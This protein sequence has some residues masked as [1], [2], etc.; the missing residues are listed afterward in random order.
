MRRTLLAFTLAGAIAVLS[1]GPAQALPSAACNHGTM[2]A[3]SRIPETTGSGTVTPGHEAVP[4]ETAE[5]CGHG[6]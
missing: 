1:A 5:G 6:D 2:N 3:H 4:E